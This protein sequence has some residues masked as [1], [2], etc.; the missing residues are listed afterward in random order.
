MHDWK[1][2]TAVFTAAITDFEHQGI[3]EFID[4]VD[5]H[6]FK[7][8]EAD[9]PLQDEWQVHMLNEFSHLNPRRLSKL[10]KHYPEFFDVLCGYQY[11]IWID[12]DMQVIS[13]DFVPEILS[14]MDDKG[15]VL[16]PHFDGRTD[17]YGE[18]T[19]RSPKYVSEPLDAQVEF[20]RADGFPGFN[21]L[22]ETG[23]MA[24]DLTHP[25]TR[26]LGMMWYI[27]NMVFS[28]QD[29]V[30]LPYCLWKL[31]YDPSVLP[32]SFRDFGWVHINAHKRSN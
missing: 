10:P 28:Y 22:Y 1:G 30:S 32:K 17:A 31:N 16:S 13:Q 6:F 5:Y 7:D 19:I 21:G 4:G 25:K 15:L 9:P 20:Y 3:H 14:Y 27:Q 29:Q 26:E 24:R 23:V 12:G 18:A 8:D 11:L 2:K